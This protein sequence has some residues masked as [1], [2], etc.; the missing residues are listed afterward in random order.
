VQRDLGQSIP[1]NW[2]DASLL[3]PTGHCADVTVNIL[4]DA[5][6]QPTVVEDW[7]RRCMQQIS[8][9]VVIYVAGQAAN[10][11]FAFMDLGDSTEISSLFGIKQYSMEDGQHFSAVVG[12]DHPTGYIRNRSSYSKNT[13]YK[14]GMR[15]TTYLVEHGVSVD[16]EKK[17]LRD[18]KADEDYYASTVKQCTV[19]LGVNLLLIPACRNVP[20]D[21]VSHRKNLQHLVGLRDMVV[22]A[23]L[24]S[25]YSFHEIMES[26]FFPWTFLKKFDDDD[27]LMLVKTAGSALGNKIFLRNVSDLEGDIYKIIRRKG[28]RPFLQANCLVEDFPG[29]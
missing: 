15:V 1:F 18:F 26:Q 14:E 17:M 19:L 21:V 22:R 5:C 4:K 12:Y 27:V 23:T 16:I 9:G 28:A 20:L 7:K 25:K 3:M 6:C 8:P 10:Q 29:Y 2:I 24:L 13:S 11:A